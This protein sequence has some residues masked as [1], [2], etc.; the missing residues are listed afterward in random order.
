MLADVH[1]EERDHNPVA[2]VRGE[3]D[4]SNVAELSTALQNSVAQESA[5][6]VVDFT[7]TS[8]LDSAGIQFIFD[9]GKRLR[10]RGQKLYLVVPPDSAVAAVLEIVGVD[11]LAPRCP[12]L[13]GALERLRAHAADVPPHASA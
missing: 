6:M 2:H 7:D 5:G 10:D 11:V 3:I 8:Y 1:F 13:D 9:L 12:S 4:L